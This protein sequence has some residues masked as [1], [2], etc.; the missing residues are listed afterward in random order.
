MAACEV[1]SGGISNG[2]PLEKAAEALDVFFQS[3]TANFIIQKVMGEQFGIPIE[4]D[5]EE[6]VEES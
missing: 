5:D 2:E 1:D 6:N 3:G 4:I